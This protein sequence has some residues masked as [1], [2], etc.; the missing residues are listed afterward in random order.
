MWKG[1]P[2]NKPTGL[3]ADSD[4]IIESTYCLQVVIPFDHVGTVL[5]VIF[6]LTNIGHTVRTSKFQG[7]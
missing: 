5:F 2:M 7:F 6:V 1:G 3:N 4:L